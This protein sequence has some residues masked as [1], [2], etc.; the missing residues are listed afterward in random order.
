MPDNQ[1]EITIRDLAAMLELSVATV[2]R[3]LN[4]D[5]IVRP[6]TKKR[7][8]EM[9]EK[10]GYSSNDHGRIL[11][12]GRSNT[13]GCIVPRLDSYAISMVVAG[14]ERSARR[15]DYSLVVMQS[16]GCRETEVY[17][18]EIL[19]GKRVDGLVLF[20]CDERN[21]LHGFKRFIEKNMPIVV[22]DRPHDDKAFVNIV[23]DNRKAAYEMTRH[24]LAQG[25][26][27][28][29]HITSTAA[30]R[31]YAERYEGYKQALLE[32][33]VS[34]KASSVMRCD[35]S[36]EGGM[37]AVETVWQWKERPDAI[38]AA[39]DPCAVGCI[40][41]LKRRGVQIPADVAVAGFGNEPVSMASEPDLTTV[42][43]PGHE[44]GEAAVNQLMQRLPGAYGKN[45]VDT[46][47]LRSS[48]IIRSSTHQIDY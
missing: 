2:S 46:V 25:R 16:N 10:V 11:R 39:N 43:F 6:R 1:K 31:G 27:R 48:L 45:L 20:P 5:S 44:M 42:G 19:L 36:R 29:V 35:L 33:G 18:A 24:L 32:A 37:R 22:L 28:I 47:L 15:Q 9:A 3:A 34:I 23:A 30:H 7:V 4:H 40:M 13:I 14:I 41:A 38:F 8:F 21:E 26:R 12:N 17:C